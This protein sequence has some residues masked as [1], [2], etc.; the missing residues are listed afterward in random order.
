MSQSQSVG[1]P[2]SRAEVI[3]RARF[4]FNKGIQ[5]D[6]S[7]TAPDPQGRRYR[8][9]CS[10]YVSMALNLDNSDTS[11]TLPR[12]GIKI[13]RAD[14]KAGDFLTDPGEHAFLF[15]SWDSDHVHFWY[16]TFGGKV[17]HHDHTSINA[18]EFDS[19]PSSEY[20]A[21][22]YRNIVDDA[23]P[24]PAAYPVRQGGQAVLT[25]TERQTF[26]I[27]PDGNLYVSGQTTP[28]TP[29]CGWVPLST[30][31]NLTG[32]PWAL[33]NPTGGTSVYARRA[34]G[35]IVI[36]SQNGAGASFSGWAD[37]GG[38]AAGD[39]SAIMTADGIMKVFAVGP[40]GNLY[41]SG[42][43]A[44]GSAFSPWGKLTNGV[45]LT[46]RPWAMVNAGGGAEVFARTS[47]GTVTAIGASHEGDGIGGQADLGRPAAALTGDPTAVMTADGVMK[48][49]DT[50]ADGKLYFSGQSAAGSAFSP[51]Y[52]LAPGTVVT[53]SPWAT[54]NAGGGAEVAVRTTAGP[55]A[56][57]AAVREGGGIDSVA[58]L[59]SGATFAGDPHI[60]L[61]TDGTMKVFAPTLDSNTYVTAQSSPGS[62]F[63]P[64]AP[65]VALT[66]G[67]GGSTV[68]APTGLQSFQIHGDGNVY[69]NGQPLEGAGTFT[70][71]P[72]ALVNATGGTS[73]FAR[74]RTG[75]V[76]INSQSSAG[77]PFSGW[78]D[79]GGSVAGDPTAVLTADG[80]MKVFAVDTDGNLSLSG[81][82]FA[83]SSFVPWGPLDLGGTLVAGRPCA[84]VNAG[85]GVSVYAR[86]ADGGVVGIGAA[87]EGAGINSWA[88]IADGGLAVTG[89]PAVVITADGIMKIFV[90]AADG[91]LY[92]NGQSFAGSSFGQWG[93]LGLGTS[94]VGSPATTVNAAGGAEIAARTTTGAVVLIGA[95]Y[96]GAGIDGPAQL[97]SGPTLTGDPEILTGHD[98]T[99]SVVCTDGA[100]VVYVNSQTGPGSAFGDWKRLS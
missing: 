12:D 48:V 13:S 56:L 32:R 34:D 43:S 59:A 66:T 3:S 25:P 89:D 21:Y 69:L 45:A 26:Q 78:A 87:Y 64:W 53:G 30:A 36:T 41:F 1:G 47:G 46:G 95:A 27:R 74:D 72:W 86:T 39:P 28:G 85:G 22:R 54:V 60:V 15:D 70:G 90:I 97:N 31:G 38:S 79:L 100:G 5:Y 80:I 57:V 50:A 83:G 61:D 62:A 52:P 75:H 76:R 6:Q 33:I 2:I 35:H 81:Q 58:L 71:R 65:V 19:H 77:A 63:G 98:A 93:P 84:L 96:E 99:M 73:V 42:Q 55:V 17:V 8:T 51:W 16:Y 20:T 92:L 10:G 14:L 4:W 88:R 68:L 23:P 44:P 82:S 29:F 40:D 91:N 7:A 67:H 18:G 24:P 9:D 94:V 37:L 11:A 49:F